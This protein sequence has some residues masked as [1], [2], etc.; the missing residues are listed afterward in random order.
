MSMKSRVEKLEKKIAKG[1][2]TEITVFLHWGDKVTNSKTGEE[3]TI[4]QWEGYKKDHPDIIEV[5][6]E[7]IKERE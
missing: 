2:G 4:K 7:T 1:Q 5:N 3:Y 6:Q